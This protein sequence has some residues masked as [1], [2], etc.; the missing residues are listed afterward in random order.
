MPISN[1]LTMNITKKITQLLFLKLL[2]LSVFSVSLHAQMDKFSSKEVKSTIHKM[3]KS[4][5]GLDKWTDA[6]SISFKANLEFL[7]GNMPEYYESV[8]IHPHS[9]KAYV[10]F[11]EANGEKRAQI[12]F[13]GKSAWSKGTRKGIENAP[14]RF[15][16]W[17]NFYLFN[18]PWLV[19]DPGVKLSEADMENTPDDLKKHLKVKMT[20]GENVGDTPK[21]Y[22][23]LFINPETYFLD[24]ATYNMT[25]ASMLPPDTKSMPTS[26]LRF[27]SY[28]NTTGL[29]MV[30]EYEVYFKDNGQHI[31]NGKV[32]DWSLTHTFDMAR[33]EKPEGAEMDKSN[34]RKKMKQE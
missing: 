22:Y 13:D 8:T 26:L 25:Y 21:D 9:R 12:A 18:L 1:L 20:F 29:K 7:F 23:V 31:I 16:A 4:H 19:H 27:K 32:K 10:D 6:K 5:G 28:D 17:R 30:K 24:A 3:T 14:P 33:L 2:L 34:P 15:T 11:L